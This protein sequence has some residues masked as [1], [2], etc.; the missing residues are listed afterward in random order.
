[1][2]LTRGDSDRPDPR[3]IFIAISGVYIGQSIIG[4]ITFTGLPAVLRASGLSLDRIGLIYL[5]ILPWT[6]KFL[7]SPAVENFRLPQRGRNR[8][9]LIVLLGGLA[10]ACGMIVAGFVGPQHLAVVIICLTLVAFA[11]STVDIACDGYAVEMLSEKH[12]GWG[13]AAQVGGA[14]LGS[15]IGSGLFL[16]LFA[17]YGWNLSIVLMTA[18]FLALALPFVLQRGVHLEAKDRQHVPSLRL[19]IRRREVHRGLILTASFVAAHKWGLSMLDPFLVDAKISLQ[20]MGIVDGIGGLAI[21]FVGAMLGGAC[22]RYLGTRAV[23]VTAL[24]AQLAFMCGFIWLAGQ[25]QPSQ[26]IL[27]ICSLASSSGIMAFGFVAL[28]AQFMRLSDVRQAGVDFTIFQCMDGA[29]S[30]VGGVLGGMIAEKFGHQALFII[31]AALIVAAVPIVYRLSER[32][33]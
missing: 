20:L 10:S 17:H 26:T 31:G 18:L 13:N 22:V 33:N 21:G 9:G 7:W 28:Y 4:G 29:M 16:V 6:L 19:A 30:M 8:S 12:H 2:A 1:M 23:L 5:V 24:V 3:T 32:Q 15:A 25:N 27:L 14:Y 11:A